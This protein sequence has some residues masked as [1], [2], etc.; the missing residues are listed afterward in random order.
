M[1]SAAAQ[2]I[3]ELRRLIRRHDH[4]YY[5]LARPTV[6]DQQYDALLAK[7]TRLEQQHR[8]LI[9]PDSPTQRVG[10]S[11]LAGFEHVEHLTPMLSIDNTYDEQQLRDFDGRVQSRLGA[12]P[13]RYV[14]D[15]K[16]DGVAVSLVYHDGV[17]HTAVTRGDGRMG[18][19]VTQNLRTLPDVPLRLMTDEPPSVCDV[20]GEVF[21]P[22]DAFRTYNVQR[23]SD[24]LEPFANPRNAASGTLKQLD[25]R[26][27]AG[28]GLRFIA[29]GFG[30]VDPPFAETHAQVMDS[31]SQWGVPTSEHQTTA[32][33]IG[34]ALELCHRWQSQ[35]RELLY[36]TDGLVIKIDSLAQ[37]DVLGAT[38]RHPRWCIAYKFA[39]D[40]AETVLRK[41]EFQVGKL[42]TI[43]PRAVM[44]PVQLSGTT[45]RHATLH[46]FDQIERLD[47]RVNDTVLIEKAG[48]IIPQVV[49][50]LKEKRPKGARKIKPPSRCPVCSGTVERDD[51]GVY[52]R[53][54]NPGCVAQLKER[55]LYFCGRDQ[56]DIEGVGKSLV[57]QLVDEGLVSDYADLY[58]L[59]EKRDQL[60]ALDRMAD[61]S[62]DNLLDGIA[63]SKSQPLSRLL[64]ALNI[65]HVGRRSGEAVAEE[66]GELDAVEKAGEEALTAVDG[67]GPELATSIQRFFASADTQ[68]LVRRLRAAGV[69]TTQ[70]KQTY[71]GDTPLNGLTV[72][73]T[74]TLESGG[75]KEIQELIKRLGGNPTGTVSAK[76]DLLIYGDSAGSK[77]AKARE[78]G[79]E[80]IDER[81]FLRRI[82]HQ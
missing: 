69:N 36:Q 72:V 12:Q 32:D 54:I 51:G 19:D 17:L 23:E 79:V 16:I 67:V 50:V 78:L 30:V 43:T 27:V 3:D 65:R 76:T 18:D 49:R 80:T 53:C 42:G 52:M 82:G 39:P 40:Q 8:N 68:K 63:A 61:K 10:E 59:H 29:H 9:T 75:R 4:A 44:D 15:P 60:V 81:E 31:L 77:L 56:M 74:G 55:L 62:A 1:P 6:S 21:W 71:T 33:D 45:V 37:R 14:V 34:E 20:R 46:N 25:P 41:V 13:Y 28:R 66:F 35:R 47:V 73:V 64:A 22:V 58:G 24:G 7:L 11:A 38:S 5:V 70:P 26:K 48:E 2:R 57:E